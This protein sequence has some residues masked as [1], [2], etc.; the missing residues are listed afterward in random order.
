LRLYL[1]LTILNRNYDE[2]QGAVKQAKIEMVS[3]KKSSA[4]GIMS[5][6]LI[7]LKEKVRKAPGP[8]HGRGG[9]QT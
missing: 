2:A 7:Y 1:T 4:Q 9:S 8:F 5:I 3:K 6:W